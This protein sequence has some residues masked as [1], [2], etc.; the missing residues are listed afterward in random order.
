V[1]VATRI[2]SGAAHTS[3]ATAPLVLLLSGSM[4][5]ALAGFV[6]RFIF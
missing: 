3:A 5:L 6:R 1:G 2:T 4:L